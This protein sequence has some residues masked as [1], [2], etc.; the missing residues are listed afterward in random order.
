MIFVAAKCIIV[1]KIYAGHCWSSKQ[2][3]FDPTSHSV[4]LMFQE[5]RGHFRSN[6]GRLKFYFFLVGKLFIVQ[7][8]V[9]FHLKAVGTI[10]TCDSVSIGGSSGPMSVAIWLVF[11]IDI[12]SHHL[13]GLWKKN[14][15]VK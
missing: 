14:F 9:N 2:E 1:F 7:F 11:F 5:G 13:L 8:Q 6:Q 10:G 4:L 12:E 15:T 3:V